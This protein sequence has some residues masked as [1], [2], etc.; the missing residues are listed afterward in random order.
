MA[1]VPILEMR[2]VGKPFAQNGRAIEAL[3][4]ANLVVKKGELI[5]LIGASGC[6][7]STLLRLAAGFRRPTSGEGL[8]WGRPLPGP[9]QSRGMVFQ[10]YGLL[11]W[12]TVRD[13]VGFGPRSRGRSRQE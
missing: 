8:M 13:N 3:R 10:D 6:G 7:K 4:D 9:G 11:P 5:C 2:N 12:L 1:E